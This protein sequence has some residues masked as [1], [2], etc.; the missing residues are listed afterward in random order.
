MRVALSVDQPDREQQR[1]PEC[2]RRLGRQLRSAGCRTR[3]V[4]L[5]EPWHQ[6]EDRGGAGNTERANN[7]NRR[8]PGQQQEQQRRRQRHGHLSEVAGEV[9]GAERPERARSGEGLCH[10][11]RGEG[12]LRARSD[13]AK[14]QPEHQNRQARAHSGKQIASARE[15]SA[16]GEHAD[17]AQSFGEQCRWNLERRHGAGIERT[18]HADRRIG[19]AE[20]RLPDRQQKVEEIG[21]SI[22]Q[23]MRAAGDR[24]RAAFV[25][26]ILRRLKDMGGHVLIVRA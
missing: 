12:M 2:L 16:G 9:V 23:E 22:V 11:G 5:A 1:K 25:A 7:G 13:T 20:L 4:C 6:Q 14:D 8:S 18:Q 17:R 21:V 3:G 15:R 19:E 26:R 24:Q 10:E